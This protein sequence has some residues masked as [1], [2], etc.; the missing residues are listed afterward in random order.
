M[1]SSRQNVKTKSLIKRIT[2]LEKALRKKRVKVTLRIEADLWL[3]IK[4][5]AFNA[6]KSI[7]RYVIDEIIKPFLESKN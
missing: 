7:N 3:K 2:I 6:G 4:K 5:L 1:P